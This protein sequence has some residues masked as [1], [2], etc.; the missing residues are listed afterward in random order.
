MF[1]LPSERVN[2]NLQEAT[3]FYSQLQQVYDTYSAKSHYVIIAGDLN[4]KLGVKL[5]REETFMRSHGKGTRNRNGH[6]LAEFLQNNRLYATN[7]TFDVPLKQRTTWSMQIQ[8][9]MR[10]N[11]ID[12][13]II[14]I[15]RL[16]KGHQGLLI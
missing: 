7:T 2:K 16:R 5:N 14:P 9:K 11:Q 15:D 10:Y 3:D 6:L 1:T 13:I 4:S 12:Y 8:G